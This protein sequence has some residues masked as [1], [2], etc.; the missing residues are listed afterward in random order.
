MFKD[1]L[2]KARKKAGYSQEGIAE[3]INTARSNISKYENGKLEPNLDTLKKL[4]ETYEVSADE[5]LEININKNTENNIT[6]QQRDFGTVN[7]NNRK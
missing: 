5:L 1:N 6:I 7:I 4:C 2:K 3:K